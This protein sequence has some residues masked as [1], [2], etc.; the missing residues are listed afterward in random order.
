MV[1]LKCIGPDRFYREKVVMP[2]ETFCFEAPTEARLEIW[3]MSLGGQM[4]HLR[5]DAADYA[6]DTYDKTLVAWRRNDQQIFN[7]GQS[8]SIIKGPI[9]TIPTS[10]QPTISQNYISVIIF[11][12]LLIIWLKSK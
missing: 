6:V 11:T 7:N 10:L 2:M 1:I 12:A 9:H 3:Q 8:R 5:A 4:L